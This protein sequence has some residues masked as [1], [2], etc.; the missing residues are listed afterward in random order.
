L[1]SNKLVFSLNT[2]LSPF[3]FRLIFS[4]LCFLL[5][6]LQFATAQSYKAD[7]LFPIKTGKPAS[8]TGNFAELRTNHYHGGIDIRTNFTTGLKVLAAEEGYVSYISVQPDGYGNMLWLTHP[9]GYVTLYAHLDR[10]RDDIQRY[11]RNYQY[12][13][14]TYF[15]DI[16]LPAGLLKVKKGDT[17]AISGNTGSSKGPHLHFEIRDTA[18][19]MYN[20]LLFGFADVQDIHPPILD[21]I[22]LKPLNI[23]SRVSGEFNKAEFTPQKAGNTYRLRE[24]VK[25]VG[26][27]GVEIIARDQI[28]G[29]SMNA[30]I[31]CYELFVNG[32][33]AFYHNH[34]K[35][36][37]KHSIH[38]NQ[39]KDYN[40]YKRSGRKFQRLYAADGLFFTEMLP[41]NRRGKII[42]NPGEQK[43]ILLKLYD[44]HGN[45]TECTFTLIGE[46]VPGQRELV[47]KNPL[48]KTSFR[49]HI[50]EN[51][52]VLKVK[53]AKE[54]VGVMHF[55]KDTMSIKQAYQSDGAAIFLW[56]LRKALPDSFKIGEHKHTFNFKTIV[57]PNQLQKLSFQNWELSFTDQSLFDTLYL[58]ASTDTLK[59]Y[60]RFGTSFFPLKNTVQLRKKSNKLCSTKSGLY[61]ESA[62]EEFKKFAGGSCVN[63]SIEAKTKFIGA[64]KEQMDTIPPVIKPVSVTKSGVKIEVYDNLSGVF[65]YKAFV[66]GKYLLLLWDKKNH[67]LYTDT[68][69]RNLPLTGMFEIM[70]KDAAG[71][72]SFYT[73]L[74]P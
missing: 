56:D 3:L 26:V 53:N 36:H 23:N 65:T 66:G 64:F 13:N 31:Y 5:L 28:T 51:T 59:Q 39:F 63:G 4:Q 44:A 68:D 72:E 34:A 50:D 43:D 7:F 12:E 54:Q 37:Y 70:V 38:V 45:K 52:L 60:T 62:F 18:G 29:G 42:I 41:P 16:V 61:T 71:N 2:K 32:E 47:I 33:M 58:E 74:I 67:L 15:A 21:L 35:V 17:I 40:E 20:P 1:K 69:D 27:V 19:M 55:K 30:G 22:A 48:G 25:A 8:L 73:K 46:E 11:V 6:A 49:H 57:L 9:N 14:E 24:P 10:F